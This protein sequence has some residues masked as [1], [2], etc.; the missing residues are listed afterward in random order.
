MQDLVLDDLRFVQSLPVAFWERLSF[1]YRSALHLAEI[2]TVC[3]TAAHTAACF[4]TRRLF[5]QTRERPWSLC[6]GDLSENLQELLEE[7]VLPSE[8]IAA[9]I[10]SLSQQGSLPSCPFQN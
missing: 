2:K 7:E 1:T 4:L 6:V 10:W 8:P 5:N 9:K 3:L